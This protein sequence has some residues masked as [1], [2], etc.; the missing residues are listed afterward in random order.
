MEKLANRNHEQKHSRQYQHRNI[1]LKKQC[2]PLDRSLWRV[3]RYEGYLKEREELLAD[4]A[5][6]FVDV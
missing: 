6:K 3:N 2:I 4:V 5:N 1:Q